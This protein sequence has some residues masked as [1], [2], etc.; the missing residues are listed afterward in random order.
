[1]SIL[2]LRVAVARV[3]MAAAAEQEGIAL[4]YLANHLAVE[5]LLNPQAYYL[6]QTTQ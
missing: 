5:H 3:I 6:L 4:P 2:L 1:L